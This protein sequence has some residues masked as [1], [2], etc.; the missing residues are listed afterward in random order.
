VRQVADV[1]RETGLE[2]SRLVLEIT[3]GTTM[4]DAPFTMATLRAL[5]ELGVKPAIDDFGNG[6]SLLSYFKRFPV[7]A[8]KIDCSIMEGLGHDRGDSAIVSATINLAH[9]WVWRSSPRA[10]KPE[11][12]WRNCKPSAATSARAT[13]GG[14]HSL[15]GR[16]RHS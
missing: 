4:E 15:P 8:I 12:R 9:A 2:A 11:R 14:H 5:R 7:D 1:L 10:W 13:T 6:Y 3:E 16:R